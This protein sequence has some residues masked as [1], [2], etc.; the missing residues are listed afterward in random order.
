[1]C[2]YVFKLQNMC[3]H[4]FKLQS[5]CKHVFKLQSMCKLVFKLQ[6]MCKLVF[7]LQSMC[8]L[9]F[10][11]QN[12]CLFYLTWEC[13]LFNPFQAN[14]PF[15]CPMKTSENQRFSDVFRGYKKGTL[16]LIR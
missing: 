3:K 13:F 5:M 6:S 1:M 12:M 10:K 8:K 4:V 11:L 15:L 16:A 7:K 2:K 9:V 14:V